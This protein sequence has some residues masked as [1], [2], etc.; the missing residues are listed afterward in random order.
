MLT[1]TKC[2]CQ[3]LFSN[4][5]SFFL[6]RSTARKPKTNFVEVRTFLHIFRSFNRMWMFSILAFQVIPLPEVCEDFFEFF[7]VNVQ[8]IYLDFPGNAHSFMEFFWI[9]FWN[10]WW[11]CFQKCLKCFYHSSSTQLY[12]RWITFL[13]HWSWCTCTLFM[14]KFKIFL[15]GITQISSFDFVQ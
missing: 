7:L 14:F 1:W 3:V 6:Q 10:Y 5:F 2:L 13:V 8:K 11:N 15:H 9:S 12:N 4:Y